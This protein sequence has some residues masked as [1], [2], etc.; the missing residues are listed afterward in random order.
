MCRSGARPDLAILRQEDPPV[1]RDESQNHIVRSVLR[2]MIV[3][4]LDWPPT[5]L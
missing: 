1:F 2:E 5:F 3:V 4:P